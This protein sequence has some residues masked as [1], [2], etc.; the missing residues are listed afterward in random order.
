MEKLKFFKANVFRDKNAPAQVGYHTTEI[1]LPVEAISH[2]TRE[3][4]Q[5]SFKIHI[6]KDYPLNLSFK[7][8]SIN[9]V[10]LSAQ[11]VELIA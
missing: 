1:Y 6:K 8:S 3:G 4:T 10:A 7:Y 9:P 11:Q 5:G 2:L